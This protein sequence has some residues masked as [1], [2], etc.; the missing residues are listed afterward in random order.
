VLSKFLNNI[1]LEEAETPAPE[2]PA[3]PSYNAAEAS[4]AEQTAPAEQPAA[5]GKLF[6][7]SVWILLQF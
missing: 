4:S 2:A 6:F 3:A 7:A 1:P 5:E